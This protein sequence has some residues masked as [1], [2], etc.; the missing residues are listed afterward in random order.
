MVVKSVTVVCSQPTKRRRCCDHT[1]HPL[2]TPF[3]PA[4]FHR[5]ASTTATPPLAVY[6]PYI[7]FPIIWSPITHLDYVSFL[8]R[9][10]GQI[11]T[12]DST[13]QKLAHEHARVIRSTNEPH[14]W[15]LR[16]AKTCKKVSREQTQPSLRSRY[17]GNPPA[18]SRHTR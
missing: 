11:Q 7:L 6:Y 9:L 14:L 3:L 8:H 18:I 2:L 4:P 10:L 12:L 15:Y 17:F 13:A 5:S 1:V 16:K